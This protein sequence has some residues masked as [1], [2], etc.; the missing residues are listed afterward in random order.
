MS[1]RAAAASA[2]GA[3]PNNR[4]RGILSSRTPASISSRCAAPAQTMTACLANCVS[5]FSSINASS[6]CHSPRAPNRSATIT[7]DAPDARDR[8]GVPASPVENASSGAA[9]AMSNAFPAAAAAPTIESAGSG[10]VESLQADVRAYDAVERAVAASV[11]RFGGLD[12]LINNAGVGVF[13]D[14]ASMTPDQ[15]ADVIETNL[16]G[17]FNACHASL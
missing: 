10:A 16:T 2:S 4:V 1:A 6:P 3:V 14:V 5:R 17:P 7:T 12:I 15:W 9:C 13:A 8:S 11:A